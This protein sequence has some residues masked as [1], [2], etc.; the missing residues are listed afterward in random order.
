MESSSIRFGHFANEVEKEDELPRP[1]CVNL[2]VKVCT[3]HLHLHST[4]GK[5]S[6]LSFIVD[7][8]DMITHV[9]TRMILLQR[10]E[11][12]IFTGSQSIVA[13]F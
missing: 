11:V 10:L 1:L 5:V 13:R 4:V 6:V 9:S 3:G 2:F 8:D 7:L 12:N